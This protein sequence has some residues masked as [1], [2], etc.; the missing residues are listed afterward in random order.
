M[1]IKGKPKIADEVQV[2]STEVLK[3]EVIRRLAKGHLSNV[4]SVADQINFKT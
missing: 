3:L 1:E 4:Q 2:K